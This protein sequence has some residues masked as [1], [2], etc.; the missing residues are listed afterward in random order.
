LVAPQV[1]K[2]V[3]RLFSEKSLGQRLE[4][5]IR[6]NTIRIAQPREGHFVVV[7]PIPLSASERAQAEEAANIDKMPPPET[8]GA[9]IV[10]YKKSSEPMIEKT[11]MTPPLWDRFTEQRQEASPAR[12][13]SVIW[14]SNDE[15]WI[16]V[17]GERGVA[18]GLWHSLDGGKNW[19]M[20]D[21]FTSVTSLDLTTSA[22][23]SETLVVAEERFEYVKGSGMAPTT[24]R[25]VERAAG[26][27][28]IPASAPPY[29][30]NSEIDICGTLPDGALHVRV[31]GMSYREDTRSLFRS[32]LDGR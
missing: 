18:G 1:L 4:P 12:A 24:A 26:D 20:V 27:S 23:G 5:G 6:K 28:W 19:K 21:E 29:G 25:V 22:G 30:S 17:A 10:A 8:K 15:I 31:D 9:W 2:S 14:Q 7:L 16:G 11:S 13:M 32:L 3:K